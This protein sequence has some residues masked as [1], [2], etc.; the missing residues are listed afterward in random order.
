MYP[1]QT[2]TVQIN[3]LEY[4]SDIDGDNQPNA[5]NSRVTISVHGALI[6]PQEF[7]VL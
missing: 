6:T 7:S 3:A 1:H 5:H 2:D 4:D